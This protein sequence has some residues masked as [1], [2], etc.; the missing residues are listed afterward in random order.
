MVGLEGASFARMS[1][2]S[3]SAF[4]SGVGIQSHDFQ[5]CGVGTVN[6]SIA[7]RFIIG[8]FIAGSN[9]GC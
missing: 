5:S 9:V 3:G 7:N 8:G 1:A 4:T 2:T 6:A